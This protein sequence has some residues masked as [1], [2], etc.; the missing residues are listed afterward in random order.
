[1]N[2]GMMMLIIGLGLLWML[3]RNGPTMNVDPDVYEEDTIDMGG[4]C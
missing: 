2:N 1:M 4:S 3:S